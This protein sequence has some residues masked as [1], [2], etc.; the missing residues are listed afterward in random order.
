MIIRPANSSI[1]NSKREK[2]GGIT[3][4][5]IFL[6]DDEEIIRS[7]L[8]KLINWEENGF[9]ISGEASDGNEALEKIRAYNT[10]ILI[11]DLKM[12][13]MNGLEL[14]RQI[15]QRFP[16]IA[17]IILTGLDDFQNIQECLRSG[18]SDYLLKPVSRDELINSLFK[19][20]KILEEKVIGYPLNLEE[21]IFECVKMN[22]FD[23]VEQVTKEF[24][25]YSEMNKIPFVSVYTNLKR[26]IEI[27][28]NQCDDSGISIKPI[29]DGEFSTDELYS[30]LKIKNDAET[31]FVY[32]L[33]RIILFKKNKKIKSNIEN[34]K[35][36]IENNYDKKITLK[37]IGSAVHLNSTYI[38]QLFKKETR[39]NYNDYV[40]SVRILHAKKMLTESQHSVQAISDLLGFGTSK[41]FSK[42]FKDV[43]GMQPSQYR[44]ETRR[45]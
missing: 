4:L 35:D 43:T 37:S 27:L 44:K 12:P 1:R 14:T 40:L 23:A 17:I 8:K 6:V 38:S 5:S 36:Y 10:D 7:G 39:G 15:K 31:M 20:R 32:L 45:I 30:K 29:F 18:V 26:I 22:D 11:T 41:Y 19:I 2:Q 34:I 13:F 28:I 42:V 24:F 9:I 25:N 21:G 16:G 33:E 3:M